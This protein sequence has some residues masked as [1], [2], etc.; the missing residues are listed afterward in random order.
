MWFTVTLR[1]C[2]HCEPCYYH[3]TD[4]RQCMFIQN[5]SLLYFCDILY[6]YDF[7]HS[8]LGS[9]IIYLVTDFW[10]ELAFTG[11][12]VLRHHKPSR[13]VWL[14]S[15]VESAYTFPISY[16]FRIASYPTNTHHASHWIDTN[17]LYRWVYEY[18]FYFVEL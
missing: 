8:L 3:N 15:V 5:I 2:W 7:V 12:V 1:F 10:C 4:F 17:Q 9:E 6:P 11:F 14:N 13:P 16:N 18:I